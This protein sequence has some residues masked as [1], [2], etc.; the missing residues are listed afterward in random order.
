[1]RIFKLRSD[2]E[3]YRWLD[4]VDESG[5]DLLGELDDGPAGTLWS[6]LAAEWIEDDLN[7]GK[8]KSDFPTLGTTPVFSQRAIDTLLDLLIENGEILPL[9]VEDGNYYVFNVTRELDAFDENRSD[10][11]RFSTG[12]IM[13]VTRYA[14]HADK[15]HGPAIFKVP[16]VRGTIFVTDPF[17]ERVEKAGLTGFEFEKVWEGA[18]EAPGE[19]HPEAVDQTSK[20]RDRP[21]TADELDELRSAIESAQRYLGLSLGGKTSDEVQEAINRAILDVCDGAKH[22][23]EEEHQSLAIGLGCLWGRT[24][25]D[26]VGWDWCVATLDG[27]EFLVIAPV[28]RAVCVAP[29][30]YILQQLEKRP[31]LH[32][33]DSNTSLLLYNMLKAGML[34]ESTPWSYL[35][36]G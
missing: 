28:D 16:Q 6:P 4:L 11:V 13:K 29:I 21:L 19:A 24:V 12:R 2:V 9:E 15:L 30:E 31:N 27:H 26:T 5:F 23:S 3:G 14:F 32:P 33:S 17:V 36:I 22:P 25:C 18:P 34:P 1:M 20:G 7:A 35:P 10:V 8:P